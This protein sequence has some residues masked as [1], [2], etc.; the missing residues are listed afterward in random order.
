[1]PEIRP[2]ALAQLS[3]K[4]AGVKLKTLAAKTGL[5]AS[6]SD[7]KSSA[8]TPSQLVAGDRIA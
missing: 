4:L 1:M 3:E 2:M 7:G 6:P 5:P 8:P